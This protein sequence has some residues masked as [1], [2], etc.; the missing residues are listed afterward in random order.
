MNKF[1]QLLNK[2]QFKEALDEAEKEVYIKAIEYSKGNKSEAARLLQ[3][4][5]GTFMKKL[6]LCLTG[7][8]EGIPTK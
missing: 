3:V 1:Y 5:R 6:D 8:Y 7:L 4:S 2:K